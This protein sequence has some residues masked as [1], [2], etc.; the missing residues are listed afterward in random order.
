MSGDFDA[1]IFYEDADLVYLYCVDLYQR[2]G[3]GWNVE[4]DVHR[5]GDDSPNTLVTDQHPERDF[6]RTLAFLGALNYTLASSYAH[7]GFTQSDYNWLNPT[8]SWMSGAIQLGIW[9]SL[10]EDIGGDIDSWD[11]FSGDFRIAADGDSGDTIHSAGAELLAATF[12]N[13]GQDG[14]GVLGTH[15]VLVLTSDSRQDM[16]AGDPPVS[17]SAPASAALFLAGLSL[18]AGRRAFSGAHSGTQRGKRAPTG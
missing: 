3:A 15:Q 12:A 7:L 17:V 6:D 5:L 8:V 2:I 9:E 18:L 14:A 13:L 4:Y 10:Y 11:I 1:S 16:I